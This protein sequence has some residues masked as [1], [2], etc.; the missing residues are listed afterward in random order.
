MTAAPPEITTRLHPASPVQLGPTLAVVKN[1]V[2][3]GSEA[4]WV[5]VTPDGP[6]S[7][8]FDQGADRIDVAAWGPGSAWAIDQAPR[9]LGLADDPSRLEPHH[10]IVAELHRRNPGLRLGATNRWFEATIPYVIGQKVVRADAIQSR[11]LLARRFGPPTPGPAPIPP[12]PDAATV[13]RISFSEFH[14]LNLERKRAGILRTVAARASRLERLGDLT[15]VEANAWLQRLPGIGPWTAGW[16]T[17]TAGGD[18]DAVPLG[19]YH[20]PRAITYALI[21]TAVDS[22]D[23]ML[24][25]LA[26]YAGQRQRVVRLLKLGG[27][28][29]P[30]RAPRMARHDV[31]HL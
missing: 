23:V 3:R 8:R 16:V 12:F 1:A 14:L 25:A 10:R 29:P 27:V 18:P 17:A 15:G 13:A 28:G 6:A 5:T 21:G 31:R 19:D 2:A 30:R 9:L 11:T 22:D 24:E 20:L 7:V 4:W 26:P